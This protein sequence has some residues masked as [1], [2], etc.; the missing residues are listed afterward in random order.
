MPRPD[1]ERLSELEVRVAFQDRTLAQ[2]DEQLR[3]A[4]GELQATQRQVERLRA[5]LASP[6]PPDGLDGVGY[7]GEEGPG[8]PAPVEREGRP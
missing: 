8:S 3:W 5:Q 2:L 1:D 7:D 6:S 4:I